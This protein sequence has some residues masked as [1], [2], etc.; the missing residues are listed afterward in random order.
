MSTNERIKQDEITFLLE[1]VISLWQRDGDRC[2]PYPK[3]NRK[4]TFHY[5]DPIFYKIYFTFSVNGGIFC[6]IMSIS[7]N[8]VMNMNN[9][10]KMFGPNLNC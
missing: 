1:C 5:S 9:V 4:I 7:H 2:S 6:M 3:Y 8:N 10:R